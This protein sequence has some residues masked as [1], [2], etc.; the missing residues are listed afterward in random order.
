MEAKRCPV[1]RGLKQLV[2][3]GM[4]MQDCHQCDAVGY[5]KE[6]LNDA[7]INHETSVQHDNDI[8][9]ANSYSNLKPKRGRPTLVQDS[10]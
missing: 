1:C 3:L 2:G 4:M 10:N 6:N 5:I 8:L 9:D 7:A